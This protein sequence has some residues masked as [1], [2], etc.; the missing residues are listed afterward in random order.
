L[1]VPRAETTPCR[2]QGSAIG[3]AGKCL[4]TTGGY[5]QDQKGVDQQG[6]E[7]VNELRKHPPGINENSNGEKVVLGHKI[8]AGGGIVDGEMIIDILAPQPGTARVISTRLVRRF[9]SD[10]PPPSLVD[11]VAAV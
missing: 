6:Q 1:P 5:G 3:A 8:P 2:L 9:A 4:G 11:R 7:F 10:H